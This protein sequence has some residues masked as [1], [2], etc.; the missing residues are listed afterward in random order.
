MNLDRGFLESNDK[1]FMEYVEIT[2]QMIEDAIH[3]AAEDL[4]FYK[5][6]VFDSQE[7]SNFQSE[8]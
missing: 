3:N 8:N 1:L 4:K 7:Y 5:N 2:L 6:F